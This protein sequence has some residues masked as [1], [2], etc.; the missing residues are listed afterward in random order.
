MRNRASLSRNNLPKARL[1]AQ[2]G[3]PA[4]GV[5]AEFFFYLIDRLTELFILPGGLT[6]QGKL[7]RIDVVPVQIAGRDTDQPDLLLQRKLR[8]KPPGDGG[9]LFTR[10]DLF[11]E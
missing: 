1:R 6:K 11:L 5:A 3:R 2:I 9:D 10:A 7:L 8:K 4:D